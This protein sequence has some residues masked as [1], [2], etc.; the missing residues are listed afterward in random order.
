M[1]T[2]P[3]FLS[4]LALTIGAIL[5]PAQVIQTTANVGAPNI[6]TAVNTFNAG[7]VSSG[8]TLSGLSGTTCIEQVNGAL[9][10]TGSSC[11]GGGGTVT[12]TGSPA[13]TQ[14]AIM[15]GT[16]SIT[17]YPGLVYLNN[18]PINALLDL[19][20]NALSGEFCIASVTAG[21]QTCLAF[22]TA[23]RPNAIIVP[24]VNTSINQTVAVSASSPIV[25]NTSTGNLTCPTCQTSSS[26][27]LPQPETAKYVLWTVGPS[28]VIVVGDGSSTF[29]TTGSPTNT[30]NAPTSTSGASFTSSQTGAFGA[31]GPVYVLS[32][33]ATWIYQGRTINFDSTG[34]VSSSGSAA[35]AIV[36]V[37]ISDDINNTG[38]AL[39]STYNSIGF[40][41]TKTVSG[42][43]GDWQLLCSNLSTNGL[44]DTGVAVVEGT[45]Y[46]LAFTFNGSTTVTA[47]V[48]G[49]N[50]TTCTTNLPAGPM[51]LFWG[52]YKG[53]T[54]GSTTAASTFEYMYADT[55]TP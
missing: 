9:T 3:V 22:D 49:A 17:S 2:L 13:S 27:G 10:S 41:A 34:L 47:T 23:L 25:L 43:W 37:G 12:T 8:I 42:T 14:V 6:F 1:K 19:G 20:T 5:S 48:N 55:A 35:S 53:A 21:G 30:R 54:G 40:Q 4:V 38:G 32:S 33:P 44:T 31:Q 52:F 18:S 16:T 7:L 29:T 26:S 15:S 50:A 24:V 36:F 45:R 51:G 46:K 11:A 28:G 39:P